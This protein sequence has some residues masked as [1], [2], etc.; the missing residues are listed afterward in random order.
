MYN[1][2]PEEKFA[3]VAPQLSSELAEAADEIRYGWNR[4]RRG[5]AFSSLAG[6]HCGLGVHAYF[7]E[8]KLPSLKQHFY[9]ASKLYAASVNQDGGTT[10]QIDM[11]FLFA[12]LSDSTEVIDTFA[13]LEPAEYL[14]DRDNPRS[15]RYYVHMLQLALRDEHDALREKIF[16]AAKRAGKRYREEFAARRDI[17]SLLLARDKAGLEEKL[18]RNARVKCVNPWV[19]DFISVH[20]ML[21]AKLCWIKGIH[22]QIDSPLIPMALL[23]VEPSQHYDDVYD[24]LRPGW[25]PPLQGALG[26]LWNRVRR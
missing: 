22:V 5:A 10:F 2:T 12:L 24:F 21:P 9:V 15:P 18:A 6:N 11:D 17:Y 19:E 16:I 25:K 14:V 23:P 7:V 20:A 26:K 13:R 4:L 3:R 1:E 8:N